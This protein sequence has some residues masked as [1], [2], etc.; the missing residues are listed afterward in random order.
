MSLESDLLLPPRGPAQWRWL[1]KMFTRIARA[2]R[3]IS[4]D[5]SVTI[6]PTTGG[7]SLAS[8]PI[9]SVGNTTWRVKNA[10]TPGSY[11]VTGGTITI[12]AVADTVIADATLASAYGDFICLKLDFDSSG[13]TPPARFFTSLVDGADINLSASA[14]VS[15]TEAV[16]EAAQFN[17]V[18]VRTTGTIYIPLARIGTSGIIDQIMRENANIYLY[19][20]HSDF[21][22]TN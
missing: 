19:L 1:D 16:M 11:D 6:S 18:G 12:N 5:D 15:V 14:I 7:L 3:V 9:A 10:S 2:A 21:T 22:V 17:L 4:P 13:A 20:R 8:Q